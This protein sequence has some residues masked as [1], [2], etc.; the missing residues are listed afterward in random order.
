ML[1]LTGCGESVWVPEL[2]PGPEDVQAKNL[3]PSPG[4]SLVYFYY[5]RI[6][7]WGFPEVSLHNAAS[8]I[9]NNMY[10]LW[11]VSPGTYPLTFTLPGRRFCQDIVAS[12]VTLEANRSYYF[13]LH[14]YRPVWR[15][16][17]WI[18]RCYD[19]Q[20]L[21]FRLVLSNTSEGQQNIERFSLVSWFRDGE[22]VYYNR[23]PLEHFKNSITYPKLEIPEQG[24]AIP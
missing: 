21:L 20:E 22:R 16:G 2:P 19:R 3:T 10:V 14:S 24:A 15:G 7:P 12:V 11:E 23:Q 17:A 1:F 6:Y 8:L 18:G 13:R 4:K 9:N 5:G